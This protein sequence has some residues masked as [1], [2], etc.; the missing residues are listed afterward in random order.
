MVDHLKQ[1]L[2]WFLF[3]L[4]ALLPA[5]VPE[6]FIVLSVIG[7]GL[8]YIYLFFAGIGSDPTNT[9]P[10]L[11]ADPGRYTWAFVV[12]AAVFG[13]INGGRG[14]LGM[15]A[16]YVPLIFLPGFMVAV[17]LGVENKYGWEG[18]L[19]DNYY[20]AR[21]EMGLNGKRMQTLRDDCVHTPKPGTPYPI[22]VTDRM[23]EITQVRPT[24]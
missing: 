12:L 9:L 16:F 10:W 8:T 7:W 21:C 6:V 3:F 1:T 2:G 13:L 11:V 15:L 5:L 17:G 4:F 23:G 19:R 18:H 24:Q 20:D 22:F 14:V